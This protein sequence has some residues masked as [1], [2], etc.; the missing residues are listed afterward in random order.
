MV[1]FSMITEIKSSMSQQSAAKLE[2]FK[3]YNTRGRYADALDWYEAHRSQFK[4][5]VY[6]PLLSMTMNYEDSALYLESVIAPRDLMIFIFGCR[7][8]EALLTDSKHP[9]TISSS[10]ISDADI[11]RLLVEKPISEHMK[12][13]GFQRTAFQLF[14]APPVVKA[15][16][17]SV[18]HLSDI[19]IG[20]EATKDMFEEVCEMLKN[21]HRMFLAPNLKV[22]ITTSLYR[23]AVSIRSDCLRNSAQYLIAHLPNRAGMGTFDDTSMQQKMEAIEQKNQALQSELEEVKR[24]QQEVAIFKEECRKRLTEIRARER[25]QDAIEQLLRN[26][27]F[28]LKRLEVEKPDADAALKAVTEAKAHLAKKI[29]ANF[30]T[31]TANIDRFIDLQPEQQCIE[32]FYNKTKLASSALSDRISQL[33]EEL[34][35][36]EKEIEERQGEID[37]AS[38]SVMETVRKWRMLTELNAI[39]EE[40]LNNEQKMGLNELKREWE[41]N[42]IPDDIERVREEIVDEEAKID[43]APADGS[44]EDLDRQNAL[45][46]EQENLDEKIQSANREVDNW[47]EKMNELLEQWLNPLTELVTKLNE[48]YVL[49]FHRMNCAGEVH[50]YKPEDKFDIDRYGITIMVKFN[51]GESLRQLSH[52]S[53]SGGERSVATMIYLMAL[54]DLS[55]VPFRC[56]D[57]INQG[58]DPHNERR[59]F[60]TL[61]D[62]LSGSSSF[63][64]T[65]YFILTPKLLRGL[66][67]GADD[68]LHL[69]NVSGD[70]DTSSERFI[71]LLKRRRAERDDHMAER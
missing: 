45:K 34:S 58:M 62:L 17:N 9:W 10:I 54:Q 69:I 53:Q 20:T 5:P 33:Q 24:A 51:A 60:R 14:T 48:R 52:R 68:A 71:E 21:T 41:L 67:Y 36:K 40:E 66:Q 13:V 22:R 32:L 30:N 28:A 31:H 65:Q 63:S 15:Y 3:T 43:V 11:A 37:Q 23:K 49:F 2:I 61:V 64:R 16:L 59:L 18:A 46:A 1:F 50:L 70:E 6:I 27:Q 4:E 39:S 38:Q 25:K 55:I 19:P 57:E 26:A 7:E 44:K 42:S 56:V 47:R 35:T 8:D 12:A 29:S